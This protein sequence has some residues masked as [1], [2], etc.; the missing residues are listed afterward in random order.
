M[1]KLLD[2][3]NRV[4]LLVTVTV[5]II[6]GIIYYFT[7]SY[8][9]TGQVDKDLV[10]EENEIFDYVKL[11]YKLPQV[12]KSED[13]NIQ[14]FPIG[15][16]TVQR[17]FKNV[18]YNNKREHDIESGR[19][20]I[21]SVLVRTQRYRIVITESKV[22]TEDLIR[23]I[24][25]ITIIIA[26]AL[27]TALLL[28]NRKLMRNLWRPFYQMLQEI[29]GFN[30]ADRSKITKPDTEIEEFYDL[31][32]EVTAMSER[33]QQDYQLLKNFVE[34]ASHELMTPL[35]VINT[36]LDTLVQDHAIS[37]YQ[38]QI[39][40]DVYATVGKLKQL[41]KSMLILARIENKLIPEYEI[42]DLQA[43][44]LQKV[45]DFKELAA[46]KNIFITAQTS[47]VTISASRDLLSILLSNLILNAI[48]HNREGGM[49]AVTLTSNSLKVCN[50]GSL[51]PLDSDQIFQRFYKSP[52]SE[53]TGLGLTLIKEIC[54]GHGFDLAYSFE[55]NLHCFSIVF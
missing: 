3:Y 39:L 41:N 53:G 35:A 49:V 30:L 31:N 16:D 37:D 2:K 9:L 10:V 54:D 11:N 5:T 22:E 38:G 8:I 29:K 40:S 26:F 44:L 45:E 25:A 43:E 50:T 51:E 32:T 15:Q 34:N 48:R 20:L 18:Q 24:F 27:L 1:I 33:V 13:L 46:P 12:F 6:T 7:I 17:V 4:S 42:V 28:I 55:E 47:I 19:S 23:V 52:E 21:S 36:K 14:F